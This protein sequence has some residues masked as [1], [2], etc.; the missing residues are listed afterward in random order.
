MTILIEKLIDSIH[1]IACVR[2]LKSEKDLYFN[3]AYKEILKKN[4][5]RGKASDTMS[6]AINKSKDVF[7]KANFT[8]CK[9]LDDIFKKNNLKTLVAEEILG[10]S[11]HYSI[12]TLINYKGSEAMLLI[13]SEDE[14]P[15]SL[16]NY[17]IN[18]VQ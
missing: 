11:T 7:A 18:Y 14:Q 8:F 5:T 2:C 4:T 15:F 13:I 6:E 9:H 3:Q 16:D 17:T 12:R 10:G 1:S